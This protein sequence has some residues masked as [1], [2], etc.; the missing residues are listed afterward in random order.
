MKEFA[1]FQ[2]IDSIGIGIVC[3]LWLFELYFG[4][5]SKFLKHISEY[6]KNNHV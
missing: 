2:I 5:V 3:I 6:L 4:T 1:L